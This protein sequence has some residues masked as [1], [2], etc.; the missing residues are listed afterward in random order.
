MVGW[1]VC[2]KHFNWEGQKDMEFRNEEYALHQAE[3]SL[4]KAQEAIRIRMQVQH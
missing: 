4:Q 2:G 3:G 1:K